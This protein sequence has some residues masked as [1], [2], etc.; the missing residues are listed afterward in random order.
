[1]RI[2]KVKLD[3]YV[4]FYKTPPFEFGRGINFVV[5][6]N[7]SGKTAL[8]DALKLDESRDSH[9]SV[10]TIPN[11]NVQSSGEMEIE[12]EIAFEPGELLNI[13][14]QF[15]STQWIPSEHV[16]DRHSAS[17]QEIVR[18][19]VYEESRFRFS[20]FPLQFSIG[21]DLTHVS[22]SRIRAKNRLSGSRTW[23]PFGDDDLLSMDQADTSVYR[24]GKPTLLDIWID[25]CFSN[26]YKFN[27]Q[28]I[29]APHTATTN[30]LILRPDG[31]NLAQVLDTALRLKTFKCEKL[32]ELVKSVFDSVQEVIPLKLTDEEEKEYLEVYIGYYP[33]E[34]QREDLRIPLSGC[35]TGLAQVIAMLYVVVMSE[36]SQ[37]ILID[38]PQSFL[39]PDALRNLLEIFQLPQ[40]AH[41]Q[42]ILTTHSPTALASVREKTV[43][44]LDHNDLI[45]HVQTINHHENQDMELFLRAIGARLSDVFGM[46]NIIWVEGETDEDCLPLILRANNVPLFGTKILRLAHSGDFTDKKHGVSSVKLYRRLSAGEALLPPALAFVFDA[47]L[48]SNLEHVKLEFGKQVR[49]LCRQN[50]ES[51]LIDANAIT[52]ILKEDDPENTNEYTPA[53]V[54]EWIDQNC[55]SHDY[56]PKKQFDA[57]QWQYCIDG[58][59]F[60]SCLFKTV[61]EDR[62]VYDKIDHTPRL[63]KLI[64]EECPIHFQEIVD[65]ITSIL[66]KTKTLDPA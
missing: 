36:H 19:T 6:K 12:F 56:Y 13:T 35:G 21:D 50:Y 54:Q 43:L 23:F 14:R 65:L 15:G 55:E 61:S 45:S 34:L 30:E 10:D 22:L 37:I 4:S 5:G 58:A 32:I 52:N 44:L 38:E 60:I 25:H 8:L 39:H 18:R 1:M 24:E 9:R 62:V 31:S 53:G 51:Y 57:E 48:E 11:P 40:Y 7:N 2:T 16:R 28:R 47:D 42:Y 20:A 3:N 41:H 33:R 27:A 17:I 64:L 63:T 29:A 59:K 49:F 26:I 46:D 66:D